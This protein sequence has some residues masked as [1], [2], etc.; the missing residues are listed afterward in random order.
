V[1][2]QLVG[3]EVPGA[4]LSSHDGRVLPQRTGIGVTLQ[5][6]RELLTELMQRGFSF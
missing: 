2:S 4:I 1:V 5:A 3:G 6:V